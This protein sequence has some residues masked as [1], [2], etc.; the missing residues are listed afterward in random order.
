MRMGLP[1]NPAFATVWNAALAFPFPNSPAEFQIQPC[2]L[3]V[4]DIERPGLVDVITLL[5]LFRSK[6][7]AFWLAARDSIRRLIFLNSERASDSAGC[8][9]AHSRAGR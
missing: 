4:P 7:P 1:I 9:A 8:A 3:P 6:E 2:K 5:S